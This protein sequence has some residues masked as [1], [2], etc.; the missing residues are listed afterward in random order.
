MADSLDAKPGSGLDLNRTVVIAGPVPFA[1]SAPTVS[2]ATIQ[3]DAP[4]EVTVTASPASP[5]LLVL[6]DTRHPGW[7]AALDGRPTPLLSADGCLRAVALPRPGPHTVVFSYRPT[8]FRLG[9]YLSLLTALCLTAA[10][11]ANSRRSLTRGRR[12]RVS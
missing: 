8:S 11:A 2:A 4:D 1:P 9:L 7:A 3:E 6:A 12:N 5:S 10:G